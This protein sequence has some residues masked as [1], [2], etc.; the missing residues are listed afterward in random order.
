[1]KIAI[2]DDND[3]FVDATKT[4]L[5]ANNYAVVAAYNGT[6]GFALVKK[7][8]PDLLLLD[9]MMA[10]DTEGFMLANQLK[11]DP[12]TNYLPIIIITGIKK[13]KGL[14]FSYEP[15]DDWLPVK[16]VMEKPMKPAELLAK[17]QEFIK[18]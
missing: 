17:I 9:V 11:N 15:D 14:P 12:E 5:E 13:E 16:A 10:H 8:K 3:D 2:I 4:L 6:D 1:M 7:E 18:K